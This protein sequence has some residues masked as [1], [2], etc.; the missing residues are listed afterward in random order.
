MFKT[1]KF[2]LEGNGSILLAILFALS[3]RWAFMEAY[4]IPSGS[5]LPTLLINDHIFVNKSVYG[6]RIPFS[7]KW[8]VKFGLPQKGEVIVFKWPRDISTSFIK[9]VVATPGD[10]IRYEGGKIYVN[11]KEFK[12][13]TPLNGG[14]LAKLPSEDITTS[15]SSL[16]IT[17]IDHK[18]E[19]TNGV[20]H[21]VLEYKIKPREMRSFGP[22]EVP[23]GK[24]FVMGDNRDDSRDS[25]EWG[26]VPEEYILGRAMFVWL[27]C[28]KTL[29]LI[30]F[31]CNPLEIRWNRFF[32]SIHTPVEAGTELTSDNVDKLKDAVGN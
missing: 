15:N 19:D 9:R 23:E 25:R 13:F 31:L 28:H 27:S 20:F 29:P 14:T 16:S 24:L 7:E 1:K 11:D 2:W 21:D 30:T 18:V 26:F 4:V 32:H 10:V 8:L 22:I 12:Q 17:D 5:M 3:I 6:V